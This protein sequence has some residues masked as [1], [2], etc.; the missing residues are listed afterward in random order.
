MSSQGYCSFCY[1]ISIILSLVTALNKCRLLL[2]SRHVCRLQH[3]RINVRKRIGA[4]N[5]LVDDSFATTAWQCSQPY[6]YSPWCTGMPWLLLSSTRNRVPCH[7]LAPARL[8]NR[9]EQ[10]GRTRPPAS[11]Q[12]VAFPMGLLDVSMALRQELLSLSQPCV[13]HYHPPFL[14][15]CT[16]GG[17]FLFGDCGC[18][19]LRL[20]IVS[21]HRIKHLR[22]FCFV[23]CGWAGHS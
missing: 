20:E 5:Q 9:T 1:R 8:V 22:C 15:P 10:S 4:K 17:V 6:S 13:T 16:H 12:G 23:V 11:M 21:Q 7:V 14:S 18:F 19:T 3:W 2:F